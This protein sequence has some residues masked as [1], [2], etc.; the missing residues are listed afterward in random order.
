MKTSEKQAAYEP[1]AVVDGSLSL[2]S[3]SPR[4]CSTA[5]TSMF[6]GDL[7]NKFFNSKMSQTHTPIPSFSWSQTTCK[8]ALRALLQVMCT[9]TGYV[10]LEWI[11]AQ[12]VLCG[13]RDL[14]HCGHLC[15]SK[16]RKSYTYMLH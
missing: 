5:A 16:W 14:Y 15:L 1:V 12:T 11:E 4:I 13:S 7:L 6:E 9:N 10:V 2:F 8:W 3:C